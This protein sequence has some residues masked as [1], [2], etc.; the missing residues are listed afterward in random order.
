MRYLF[1]ILLAVVCADAGATI[2]T[3]AIE[4]T[5]FADF[6]VDGVFVYDSSKAEITDWAINTEFSGL[7]VLHKGV[8]GPAV[9]TFFAPPQPNSNCG[10][11]CSSADVISPTE[12]RFTTGNSPLSSAVLDLLLVTPL[13]EN[14]LPAQEVFLYYR[15]FPGPQNQISTF[16]VFDGLLQCP[17]SCGVVAAHLISL[18]VPEPSKTL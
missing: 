6:G 11:S 10:S 7:E 4:N 12:F 14:P 1:A 16:T 5:G 18:S 9:H 13:P 15:D 17:R 2:R 8:N 3:W